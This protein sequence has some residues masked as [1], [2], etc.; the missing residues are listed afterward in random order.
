MY[1]NILAEMTRMQLDSKKLAK[2]MHTKPELLER[3]LK[4]EKD[5]TV[6]DIFKMQNIFNK[7]YCTFEYLLN[8]KKYFL[9]EA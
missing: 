1:L 7:N 9:G 6:Q 2:F 3:K 4:K 8:E 5:F